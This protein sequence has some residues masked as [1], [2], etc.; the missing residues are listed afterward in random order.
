MYVGYERGLRLSVIVSFM[1]AKTFTKSVIV[2][3]KVLADLESVSHLAPLHNPANLTGIRAAQEI[4]PDV[5]HCAVM[6]TA[7]HQTMPDTSYMYAL[8]YDW[9]TEH[10]VRRYGFHGTSY[11]YTAKRASVLLGKDPMKTNVIIAHIGNGASICAVKDGKGFDTS[12]GMTP[13]EGL[14]MGTRSGDID[15]AIVTYMMK[16][17]NMTPG[18]MDGTL[19]KKSG[20]LGITEKFIDRRDVH[21]GV[22]NGDKRCSL[23]QNMGNIPHSEIC[24][25]VLCGSR[26]TRC[27]RVH[28]RCR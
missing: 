27:H 15:P 23:A 16:S 5:P 26:K 9:Y 3:D 24:R 21:A 6:D 19:N 7:W 8:P 25:S 11:I 17:K 14:V 4:L 13:L 1:E 28:G 22:E 18:E 2:D 10:N 20:I 12:M